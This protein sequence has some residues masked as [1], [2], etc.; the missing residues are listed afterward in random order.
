MKLGVPVKSQEG[1]VAYGASVNAKKGYVASVGTDRVAKWKLEFDL[2]GTEVV[3]YESDSLPTIA[4]SESFYIYNTSIQENNFVV[5]SYTPS[6]QLNWGTVV[7]LNK[8]PVDFK[9]DDLTQE[10]TI[11]LY[12]EEQLPLDSDE[13][14]YVVIDRTGNAR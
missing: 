5:V 10:L 3:K 6:G 4:G 13:L 9:F 11:L 7:S 8:K 2:P 1:I 12:P 14:G